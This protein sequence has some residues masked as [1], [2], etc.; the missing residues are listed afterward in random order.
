M[1]F[2]RSGFTH[3]S[4]LDLCGDDH[5]GTG[6][7]RRTTRLAVSLAAWVVVKV[8]DAVHR[9]PIWRERSDTVI[10]ARV[11]RAEVDATSEQLWARQI[12]RSHYEI[13]C[14]PFFV[15]DLAL[16]DIVEVDGDYEV[17]DVNVRSG[18]HV[19]RV[20]FGDTYYPR[21]EI[22]Q[23][24]ESLEGIYEWSSTNLLAVDARDAEHAQ[25]ISDFLSACQGGGRFSTRRARN[26]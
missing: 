2:G 16:G 4:G 12:D 5:S 25:R 15:Y 13:C 23:G 6:R 14:I 20:W 21:E 3:D 26:R 10:A 19:F 24:L 18:R 22:V 7:S 9:T 11:D 1:E 17:T 8:V